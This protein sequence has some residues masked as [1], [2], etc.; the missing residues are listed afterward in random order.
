MNNNIEQSTNKPLYMG[1][2]RLGM[3]ENM[4]Y[5]K[6]STLTPHKKPFVREITVFA[7]PDYDYRAIEGEMVDTEE[8]PFYVYA[9]ANIYYPI[10]ADHKDFQIIPI[11]SGG[12]MGVFGE[13]H[14][15]DIAKEEI[16]GLK[17]ILK[18]FHVNIKGATIE[19]PDYE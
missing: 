13:D 15:K 8:T 1:I 10:G 2:H 17:Q 3:K 12:C 14:V 16:Y 19:G 5:T 6:I 9:K 4:K 18:D 11:K 7:E